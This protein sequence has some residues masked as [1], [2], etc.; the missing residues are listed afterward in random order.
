MNFLVK[1]LISTLAVL[2]TAW[3]LPGVRI[4]NDSVFVAIIVACVL[5]FLNTI[6][7]PI[8][9]FLTIPITLVTMGLFL[10]V[11]NAS[12]IM[13]TVKLVKGFY[14]DSFWWALLFSIV[15]SIVNSI[16]SNLGRKQ[17]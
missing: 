5:A 12:I 6:V 13:L 1:L 7:K 9:I 10:L 8:L 14:V 3:L 11:I 4:E 17:I 15:L 16:L 2:I